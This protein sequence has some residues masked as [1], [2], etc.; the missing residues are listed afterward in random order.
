MSHIEQ[1][2]AGDGKVFQSLIVAAVSSDNDFACIMNA[3]MA[4]VFQ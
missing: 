3:E 4:A 1:D 2:V